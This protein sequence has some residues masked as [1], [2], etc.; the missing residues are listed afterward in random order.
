M[1]NLINEK[2]DALIME[3]MKAHNEARTKTLRAIKNE[4]LKW[5]TAKENVGKALDEAAEIQL[6][7]KMVKTRT[8][9]A[10]LYEQA[11]RLDLATSEKQEIAVIETFLPKETSEEEINA[12]LNELISE[13]T[14]E[15]SQKTMGLFI[16]EIKA[17]FPN[18]NGKLIADLVKA[19]L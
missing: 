14:T 10:D 1:N 12:R 3:S 9:S 7:K 8:E 15:L 17:T 16:K 13:G 4:F 2:I 11:H 5:K 18:A 19:R 6:L